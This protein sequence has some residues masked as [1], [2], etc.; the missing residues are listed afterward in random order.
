MTAM[1]TISF[2]NILEDLE[3]VLQQRI[4]ADPE[5][6]YV[7][8]LRQ[9]GRDAIAQKIGEEAF[10]VVIAAKNGEPDAII[11]EVADLWFHTMILL[12]EHGIPLRDILDELAKR[13]NSNQAIAPDS[14]QREYD[15]RHHALALTLHFSSG[16]T[17]TGTTKDIS[18]NGILVASDFQPKWQ[19]TGESGHF[20]LWFNQK[21]YRFN[22][23]VIRVS[24]Q[25]IAIQLSKDAG[26]FGYVLAKEVFHDLF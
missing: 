26:L 9:Q 4:Q 11:H 16:L 18:L 12:L 24:E 23:E 22:F 13:A 8:H 5:T 20:E 3:K 6:S 14:N 7:A 2:A 25:D 19:L 17:V 10:E 21:A 15:R 1:R